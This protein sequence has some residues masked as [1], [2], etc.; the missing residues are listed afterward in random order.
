M[1]F[2]K[3]HPYYVIGFFVWLCAILSIIFLPKLFFN[4]SGCKD[5]DGY[6]DFLNSLATERRARLEILELGIINIKGEFF[7]VG[8]SAKEE[9]D[10]YDRQLIYYKPV[11]PVDDVRIKRLIAVNSILK[12]LPPGERDLVFN[13]RAVI[14]NRNG[15]YVMVYDKN[16]FDAIK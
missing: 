15:S 16:A 13:R 5:C 10:L 4:K 11:E 8:D 12:S 7:L 3:K 9:G 14:I 1:G 2:L 6:S